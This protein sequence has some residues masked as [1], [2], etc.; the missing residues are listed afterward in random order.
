VV[1]VDC[2]HLIENLKSGGRGIC[3]ALTPNVKTNCPRE[4]QASSEHN[5]AVLLGCPIFVLFLEGPGMHTACRDN[6][7]GGNVLGLEDTCDTQKSKV[8]LFVTQCVGLASMRPAPAPQ[9]Q[10]NSA[11]L[12]AGP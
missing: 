4:P 7:D 11:D 5:I 9:S 6:S 2:C 8:S 10:G 1:V 3:F 12:L